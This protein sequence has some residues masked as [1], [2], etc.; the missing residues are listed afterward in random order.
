MLQYVAVTISAPT[1]CIC[2]YTQAH[3]I[4]LTFT[5]TILSP[6]SQS[7]NPHIYLIS[8][9]MVHCDC[10]ILCK[11]GKNVSR[12]TYL[13]HS[14]YRNEFSTEFN[15]F[16]ASASHNLEVSILSIRASSIIYNF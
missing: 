8:S 12:K 3:M 7:K 5:V 13:R 2:M 6:Q 10:Q 9:L 11:G 14:K 15:T 1:P 16:M 4:Y